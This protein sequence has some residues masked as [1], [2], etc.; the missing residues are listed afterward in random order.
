MFVYC[1]KVNG[2]FDS[3]MKFKKE[4]KKQPKVVIKCGPDYIFFMFQKKKTEDGKRKIYPIY[5]YVIHSFLSKLV[6]FLV[7]LSLF[8]CVFLSVVIYRGDM[9]SGSGNGNNTITS[10]IMEVPNVIASTATGV[11]NASKNYP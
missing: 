3:I 7:F 5:I 9:P 6:L 1:V 10:T 8:F 11:H 4:K 2:K